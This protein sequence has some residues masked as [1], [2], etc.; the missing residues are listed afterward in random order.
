MRTG[1][2]SRYIRV[3][4][5][6]F[7]VELIR[8]VLVAIVMIL[9]SIVA[10]HAQISSEPI[11]EMLRQRMGE[12]CTFKA[13]NGNALSI[14]SV[15]DRILESAMSGQRLRMKPLN[16]TDGVKYEMMVRDQS[17]P[18]TSGRNTDDIDFT[19]PNLVFI[20]SDGTKIPSAEGKAM[21]E[22]NQDLLADAYNAKNGVVSEYKILPKPKPSVM[23]ASKQTGESEMM[24]TN[25]P[26]TQAFLEKRGITTSTVTVSNDNSAPSARSMESLLAGSSVLKAGAT[27]PDFDVTDI[28]GKRWKMSELQTKTL[29]LN[30]WFVECAPCVEEMPALNALVKAYSAHPNVVFLSFAN[31]SAAKLSKFLSSKAFDY[32]HIPQEQASTLLETWAV[33]AFPMN[34][35]VHNGKVVSS[36]TGGMKFTAAAASNAN[37]DAAKSHP[38]YARIDKALKQV[39]G[40]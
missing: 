36:M 39:L 24:N 22:A 38:M 11:V 18:N 17:V 28:A 26:K 10:T 15:A 3:Q 21:L 1:T 5:R 23:R 34:T 29:V 9:T 25:D 13:E 8:S 16:V 40:N 30:F 7:A 19:T 12:K 4:Q 32:A 31:S 27:M 33:N 37:A 20:K 2:M 35:V 14:E 6:R